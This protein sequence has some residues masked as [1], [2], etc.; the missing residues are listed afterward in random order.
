MVVWPEVIQNIP[1]FCRHTY[2]LHHTTLGPVVYGI[3]CGGGGG[4]GS[5]KPCGAKHLLR[6]W[7]VV[8]MSRKEHQG[9][10]WFVTAWTEW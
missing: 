5:D 8:V 7:V 2:L 1:L 9:L 6:L 3:G 10:V 4:G